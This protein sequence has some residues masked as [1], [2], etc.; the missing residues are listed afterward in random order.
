[1]S[2]V[3]LDREL[4]LVKLQKAIKFIPSKT[5]IPAFENFRMSV[6]NGLMS[7]V[8]SDGNIQVSL[9][10]PV[11]SKD[12]FSFCLPAKLLLK[13]I[14]LFR[15]NDVTI[16]KKTDTKFEIKSGKSKY[17]IGA[18]CDIADFPMM[19]NE[20]IDC[21]IAM[22]QFFLQKALKMTERFV[23]DKSQNANLIGIKIEN[24]ENKIV[25]TGTDGAIM[26]RYVVKPLSITKWNKVVIP[27]ETAS[28]VA[29]LLTDKGDIG[30][31]LSGDK[32]TFFT[33]GDSSELFQVC[34]V[35]SNAKFP[36]TEGLFQKRPNECIVIN[37]LEIKDA[38]KR[39]SLYSSEDVPS[40]IIQDA[41]NK[42]SLILSSNDSLQNRDG[43][44]E[45]TLMDEIKLPIM[46]SFGSDAILQVLNNV[47]TNE[48]EFYYNQDDKHPC[49][50]FPRV[51][52]EEE[53]LSS[54]LIVGRL[55]N[56][57]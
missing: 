1:M 6:E 27:T 42:T 55:I 10:C 19:R 36:N 29:S 20:N 48:F 2:K 7:I 9:T 32:V 12:N 53:K 11:S 13:T 47:D 46:K 51:N 8:A 14:S 30:I 16:T 39:L 23:D 37:T 28:R 45:I 43:E 41:P 21:E 24:I 33:D 56:Q 49:F 50:I 4:V 18:Y 35:T 3:K 44:E 22:Q 57:G 54:F 31:S 5:T 34:S 25:F 52:S 38:I 15:E 17:N 40:F 26:C